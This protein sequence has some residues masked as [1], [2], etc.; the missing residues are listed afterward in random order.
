MQNNGVDKGIA[1]Q[2][3]HDKQGARLAQFQT[4]RLFQLSHQF[5]AA[6]KIIKQSIDQRKFLTERFTKDVKQLK[7]INC[8]ASLNLLP[9]WRQV[10]RSLFLSYFRHLVNIFLCVS[11]LGFCSVYFVFIASNLQQVGLSRFHV[12]FCSC[13]RGLDT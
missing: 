5:I 10:L 8:E 3:L 6:C 2:A 7:W 11:Q 13:F 12:F 9:S 1:S 4:L